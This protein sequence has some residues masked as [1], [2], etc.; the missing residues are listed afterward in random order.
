[1]LYHKTCYSYSIGRKFTIK[2]KRDKQI[3]KESPVASQ[4][5]LSRS[6]VKPFD[7]QRCL[8]CQNDERMGELQECMTEARD[9]KLKQA[10]EDCP[11]SLALYKIRYE[12]ALDAHAGDIKYHTLCWIEHVDRRIKDF[13]EACPSVAI[14]GNKGIDKGKGQG[15]SSQEDFACNTN[16]GEKK[17]DTIIALVMYEIIHGVEISL[18]KSEVLTICDVINVYKEKLNEGGED[19]IVYSS[20]RKW[21]KKCLLKHIP[22]IKFSDSENY[23]EQFGFF[24]STSRCPTGKSR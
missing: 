12:R 19:N 23:D 18:E 9:L 8:F 1:M 4:P 20:V 11:A 13:E 6:S 22:D 21:M 24:I 10:F 14:P 17:N 2:R 7:H 16:M 15:S 5:R 3:K